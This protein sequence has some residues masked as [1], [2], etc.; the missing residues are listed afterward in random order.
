MRQSLE[1]ALA[2]LGEKRKAGV[3]LKQRKASA[4]PVAPD[5]GDF[6]APK[7]QCCA[8]T[9]LAMRLD[10][11]EMAILAVSS[12]SKRTYDRRRSRHEL[13]T[14]AQSDRLLRIARVAVE[15]EGVFGDPQKS[16]RWLTTSNPLLAAKPL[17]L[18][19]FDAGTREVE[20]ELARITYGD[21][22]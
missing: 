22:A 6:R 12:I 20:E 15:A 18:L 17:E 9:Y 10:V 21:F 13:L 5:P 7:V 3:L 1:K 16:R 2:Y 11:P 14:E 4:G 8:V 19:G